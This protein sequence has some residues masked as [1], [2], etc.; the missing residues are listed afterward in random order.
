MKMTLIAVALTATACGGSH[1]KMCTDT[2]ALPYQAPDIA[3][4]TGL[5]EEEPSDDAAPEAAPTSPPAA[6][7]PT[8]PTT[9]VKPVPAATAP[10][11]TAPAVPKR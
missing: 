8:V 11:G 4:L 1:G 5:P 9:A 10:V 6:S 2:P 7:P 3:E